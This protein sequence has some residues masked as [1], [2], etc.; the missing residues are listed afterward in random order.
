M[1]IYF[2]LPVATAMVLITVVMHSV[3]LLLLGRGLE[4]V[5]RNG[6]ITPLSWEGWLVTIGL[7]L[8]LFVLHGLEIWLYAALFVKLGA[9]PDIRDAAY[10]ST[11]SYGTMGYGD[12][13]IDEQ[14]KLLGAIEGINGSILLG[15]SVA[16]FVNVMARMLPQQRRRR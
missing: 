5:S 13:L 6:R 12:K 14:W 1:P 15:W 4:T 3:G 10:F 8:G 16:F 9:V 7:V 11:S 2:E